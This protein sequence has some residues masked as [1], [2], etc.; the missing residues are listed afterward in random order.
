[1]D[2]PGRVYLVERGHLDLFAV[3][4]DGDTPVGRKCF[5]ARVPTEEMA[6]GCER[7]A[8]PARPASVYSFLAVPALD[9][10]I[11]EGD[12][13]G[14]GSASF[15]LDATTWIDDWV[16]RLSRFLTQ[17]RAPPRDALLLEA[18]PDVSYP[19]G[20]TLSAQHLD[21][22]W[23]SSNC[24]MRLVGR[25][26]LIV[27][28][29]ESLLPVTEQTWFA[30]DRD[31]EISAVYTPTAL[32]TK[33][34]WPG[35][36]RFGIRILDFAIQ[37]EA[38][39]EVALEA[40]RHS[41]HEALG[42]SVSGALR[43]F[44][45]I[46]DTSKRADRR[47]GVGQTP[48]K[49]AAS[50]V[51]ASCGISLD[52]HPDPE[53]MHASNGTEAA[54]EML[55]ALARRSGIR[56]RQITLT[57]GWWKRDG[58][59]FVGFTAEDD[60]P[61]GV[62]SSGSGGHLAVDPESG[63]EFKVSRR[64]AARIG[65]SGVAFYA[66]LPSDI[67]DVRSTLQFS[68]HRRRV[69]IRN[70]LG[71]GM[72]SGVA[73]LLLPILTG[74]ILAEIIPR[75][76]VQAWIAALGALL[77]MA[78]GNAGF[79]VVHGLALAR[80]E[81]RVDERLQAAI[82]SRLISLPAPFFR[83]F[84]AGDLA[85]RANGITQVRR[86]LTSAALQSAVS[87]IFSL[88][89]LLLLF[90]YSWVLALYVCAMLLGLVGL[91][92]VFS[93]FQ[94]RHYRQA[95]RTQGVIQGFVLQMINGIAKI[96]VA[97]AEGYALAHW[98]RQFAKQ[99]QAYLSA[100]RWTAGQHAAIGMFRPLALGAIF[101]FSQAAT[102]SAGDESAF[103]LASFLSFY[104]AFGQL[105]GSVI[106][107]TAA[108]T[109]AISVVPLLERVQPLL[110]ARPETTEDGIHPGDLTGDI[111][112]ANVTFRYGPE[113]PNA[114]DGISFRINQ[115]DYVAL[116]GPSGCGKSTI[117]RLLLGFERPASGTVFLD[118]HDLSG[119]DPVAVRSCM[120]V[121]LQ[122][123]QLVAGSIYEN[124]A[125]M[126]PLD[127]SEAWAAA[128][129]ASLENDIKAMP[130]GMRTVVPDGGAGFSVGQKQRLMIARALARK[131]RI[132]LFDEATSALDNRAQ[133]VVQDSLKRLSVTRMVIAHRLSSI[134]DVDRIF[135]LDAG[136]IVERGSYDDLIK[137]NGLF[138]ALSRRQLIGS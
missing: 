48:L 44:G 43:Q 135:V 46:L 57:K 95:F 138:A 72:L 63:A 69:D 111:E 80:I 93:Y 34:L 98:A 137:R 113:L 130:M 76:D 42:S 109:S 31:A 62:L 65:P 18:D 126:A 52:A 55:K 128:R 73:A 105:A 47:S 118:G 92:C 54:V 17:H 45:Q 15:D 35:F 67:E 129:A 89:S 120:G 112:F 5:V 71:A 51:A 6:F 8:D 28:P 20:S 30:I 134:R 23:V 50:L 33:Q 2:D 131:P 115:G 91:T 40:R 36:Q 96:R 41:A 123:G 107:L 90:Y 94:L 106:S 100:M 122:N 22:I 136:R 58:P 37:T 110:E 53:I 19:A 39:A 56:T 49:A 127:D 66:S 29:G 77:L 24:T 83:D 25:A 10:V 88:F 14:V 108:V 97:H 82:W 1:M 32:V 133:A 61:I 13:D 85:D 74:Q 9:T 16:S 12:R 117:Y 125:G 78:F 11:V 4:L 70:L 104:A 75:G 38:E 60:Q 21:V 59:C 121:V 79:G 86:M 81:S 26:D 132:L 99:K 103:S 7:L 27:E 84:A 87:G 68:L 124:I 3:E 119:L 101:A 64:T 116:V 102:E 114:I